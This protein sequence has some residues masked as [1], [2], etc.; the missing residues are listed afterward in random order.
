MEIDIQ[1]LLEYFDT[2]KSTDY[3]DTTAAIAVVGEDLGAALFKNYCEKERESTVEIIDPNM[4]IPTEGK[5]KGRR[6]DRWIY[7]EAKDKSI[8]YQ[9]EIKSWCSRAIGGIDVPMDLSN[10]DLLLKTTRNWERSVL[11]LEDKAVNGLNK[12]LVEMPTDTRLRRLGITGPYEKEPLVIFW[13]ARSP[14]GNTGCFSRF[15]VKSK[16]HHFDYCWV[17]SCSLYLRSLYGKGIT[18][19]SV[20]IP[21]A[22]RRLKELARIFKLESIVAETR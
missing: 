15:D 16:E 8:L 4:A 7:E 13:D 11:N 22:D 18:E 1:A 3:G 10:E 17:F 12:V 2:K 14:S 20:E 6:L 19:I 5:K 21:N 9:T